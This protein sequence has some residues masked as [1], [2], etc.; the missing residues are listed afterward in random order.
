MPTFGR[1][2]FETYFEVRGSGEP[3]LLIAGLSASN[4]QWRTL[5]PFLEEHFQVIAFDNRG[6]GRSSVPDE[7][8]STSQMADDA[9]SLLD[10]L[11]VHRVTVIGWSMGG[12]I[13]QVLATKQPHR[14]NHLCLLHS[15][16]APDA[17]LRNAITNWVNMRRSSMT[18]EQV[19]RHV[20]WLVFSHAFAANESGYEAAVQLMVNNPYIQPV[21]GLIRQAE[22]LLAHTPP[23]GLA[24]LPMPVSILAGQEDRLIPLRHAEE[25]HAVI[26]HS[27]F[28]TLPGAHV[29]AA[30]NPEQYASAMLSLFRGVD[31]A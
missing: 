18:Y 9:L 2:G 1:N 20:A 6:V 29:G 12:A 15:L 21:H 27:R 24:E 22:A 8:Y 11:S 23:P 7:P 5:S 4:L 19:A 31:D 25:L 26:P 16:L 30:E 10:H 3:L 17:S 28:R 13:A 14:V